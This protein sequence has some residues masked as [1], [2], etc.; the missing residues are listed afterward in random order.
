M[1]SPKSLFRRVFELVLLAGLAVGLVWVVSLVATAPQNALE[2]AAVQAVESPYPPPPTATPFPT[3]TPT[4]PGYPAPPLG[5]LASVDYCTDMGQWLTYTN[6]SAGFS[7]QYPSETTLYDN[8]ANSDLTQDYSY[9]VGFNLYPHCYESPS[10][11]GANEVGVMVFQNPQQLRMDEFIEQKF[12]LFTN[13]PSV[14]ALENYQETGYFVE[15][16]GVRSLRVEGGIHDSNIPEIF[17]PHGNRV[18]AV[19]IGRGMMPPFTPPCAV[20]LQLLDQMLNTL[21]LFPPQQ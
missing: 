19:A 18:L 20:M 21:V 10:E 17:I 6:L 4:P 16:G 9:L 5:P 1:E 12:E 8:Q 7:I 2:P 15:I 13:P 14:H 11:C 3:V